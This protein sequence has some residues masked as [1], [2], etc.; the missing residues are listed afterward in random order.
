MDM[1]IL[2]FKFLDRESDE[3]ISDFRMR[4]IK[5]VPALPSCSKW[6]S[7]KIWHIKEKSSEFEKF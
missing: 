7:R 3:V 4:V 2:V 1:N 6:T 5:P